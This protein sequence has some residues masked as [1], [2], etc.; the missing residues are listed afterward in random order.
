MGMT[1]E[2]LACRLFEDLGGI[3][4]KLELGVLRL[5]VR[6]ENSVFLFTY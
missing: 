2:S 6:L 4:I 1:C 5:F 3:G